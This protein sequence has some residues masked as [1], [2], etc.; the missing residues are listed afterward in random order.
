M[1]PEGWG[2]TEP[3]SNTNI[4]SVDFN[5]VTKIG[6]NAFKGCSLGSIE[7]P[8]VSSIAEGADGCSLVVF[9]VASAS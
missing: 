5:M 8:V 7:A 9:F 1:I 2:T 3:I 4:T 6:K